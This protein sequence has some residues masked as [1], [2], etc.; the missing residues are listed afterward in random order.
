MKAIKGVKG[1]QVRLLHKIFRV[2]II[3][4]EPARQVVSRRK[5]RQ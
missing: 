3:A 4:G 1:A 2:M 5:M